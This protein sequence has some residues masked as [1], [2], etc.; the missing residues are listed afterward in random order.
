MPSDP[1]EKCWDTKVRFICFDTKLYSATARLEFCTIK[2][3]PHAKM[4]GLG[5]H[6]IF[7]WSLIAAL[8]SA[9][10]LLISG[11]LNLL[12]RWRKARQGEHAVVSIRHLVLAIS[13]TVFCVAVCLIWFSAHAQFTA[14]LDSPRPA[15]AFLHVLLDPVEDYVSHLHDAYHLRQLASLYPIDAH[16]HIGA[17]SPEFVAMLERANM[18]VLD[19]LYVDDTGAYR[20]SLDRQRQDALA[21]IA[22]SRGRATLCTTFDPFPVHEPD[23]AEHA[24]SSLNT[25]FANGAVAAKVWKNVGL[26]IKIASGA[27]LMPDNPV[28][29]P[30]YR[31]IAEHNKSLIIHAAEEDSAWTGQYGN[32]AGARYFQIH[33]QWDMSKRPDAPTKQEILEARDSILAANPNLRVIGAHFGGMANRLDDLSALFDRYPNFAVDISARV[34]ALTRLPQDEVRKFF[35]DHPDRILYG[36]DLSFSQVAS[37]SAPPK[38][39]R[40]Q[41]LLDWRYF[42]TIDTFVYDDHE[43]QGLGLPHDVLKKLYHDNAVRW[44]PGIA[45]ASK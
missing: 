10:S 7:E 14:S 44:I 17:S 34:R 21:F 39:W 24:I 43:V 15:R 26:E 19:I 9:T 18:R 6:R 36:T 31:D 2:G 22:S 33:P 13:A 11:S 40:R 5:E 28:F 41:Y 38:T 12:A 25:D 8:L 27:Y 4:S 23:F 32:A 20:S 3:L 1:A 16:T 35:L 42:S 30:I 37:E 29:A 45:G